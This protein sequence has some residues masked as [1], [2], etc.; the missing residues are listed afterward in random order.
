MKAFLNF[1]VMILLLLATSVSFASPPPGDCDAPISYELSTDQSG[2]K[3]DFEWTDLLPIVMAVPVF[4]VVKGGKTILSGKSYADCQNHLFSLKEKERKLHSIE[5]KI[6]DSPPA[7]AEATGGEDKSKKQ[8]PKTKSKT[9]AKALAKKT[10]T[11]RRTT[12]KVETPPAKVE[13]KPAS[14]EAAE[15]PPDDVPAK[16]E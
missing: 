12:K 7:T 11:K 3:Q 6:E 9:K 15:T 4:N 1:S 8:P 14:A 16:T 5:R 10:G 13:S 2:L